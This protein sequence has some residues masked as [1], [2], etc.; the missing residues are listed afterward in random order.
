MR[1]KNSNEHISKT[2]TPLEYTFLFMFHTNSFSK[3]ISTIH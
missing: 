1:Y 2:R 3:F